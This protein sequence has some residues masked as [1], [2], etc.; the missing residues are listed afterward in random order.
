MPVFTISAVYERQSWDI[1][2]EQN[3]AEVGMKG[4]SDTVYL[5]GIYRFTKDGKQS[6]LNVAVSG[7]YENLSNSARTPLLESGNVDRG[8]YIMEVAV[9]A[10]LL[11]W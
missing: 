3:G 9:S 7:G 6:G 2:A 8:S 5:K 11:S 10:G 1:R 4:H